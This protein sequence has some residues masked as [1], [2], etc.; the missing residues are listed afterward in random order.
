MTYDAR[1][2][3]NRFLW[4]QYLAELIGAG[5]AV[6]L[7]EEEL[8]RQTTNNTLERRNTFVSGSIEALHKQT[9]VRANN[10]SFAHLSSLHS[11][12]KGQETAYS[13]IMHNKKNNVLMF[14]GIWEKQQD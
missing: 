3:V 12:L 13:L 5:E 8:K 4:Q 6:A 2:K 9:K 14:S 10:P 11:P 7:D 1:K